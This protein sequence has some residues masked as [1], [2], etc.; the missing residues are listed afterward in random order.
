MNTILK[1]S[2]FNMETIN[3]INFIC[4]TI[5]DF[6]FYLKQQHYLEMLKKMDIC[7][8]LRVK[9]I[10]DNNKI[11]YEMFSLSEIIKQKTLVEIYGGVGYKCFY[12]F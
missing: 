1:W 12:T 8:I 7:Q 11:I 5:P 6:D 3:N 4:L 9:S 10:D 2:I